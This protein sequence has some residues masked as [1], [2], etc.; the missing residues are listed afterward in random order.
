MKEKTKLAVLISGRG[1]N[2]KAI[3]DAIK[4]G[5]LDNVELK[6]VIANKEAPG[7]KYAKDEGIPTYIV[8]R[9]VNG[10]K[11]AREEHDKKVMKILEKYQVDL[12]CMAG[13][14]QILT[15]KFI[16]RYRNRIMNI[17]PSILPAFPGTTRAQ[18]K[19]VEYGVKISGCTVHFADEGVDTGPIIIQAAVPVKDNDTE[20][21]LANRILEFEHIIYPKAIKM[22]SEG[23]LRVVG[24]K[25][26]IKK[27]IR[28]RKVISYSFNRE[29]IVK[30]MNQIGVSSEILNNFLDKIQTFVLLVEDITPREATIL[31]QEMLALGG[32]CAVP[33][34][35]VLNG[36][37]PLNVLLIGNKK[38]LKKL[39]SKLKN[40]PFDLPKV[41]DKIKHIIGDG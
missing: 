10:K 4:N 26:Y 8:P 24:R 20:E 16:E 17:H 39:V 3:I 13:Y 7:L 11:I 21:T 22:F 6:V 2:L 30:I 27:E 18:K 33:K 41:G 14:L 12:I 32:D 31:K 19:A 37:I 23:R 38:Q 1:S 35:C 9:I 29:K 36:L 5:Y 15:P 28:V 25:V 40:Q 34:E